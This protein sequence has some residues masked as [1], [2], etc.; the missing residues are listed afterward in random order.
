MVLPKKRKNPSRI[1]MRLSTSTPAVRLLELA[2]L[3]SGTKLST[4]EF[5]SLLVAKGA[6]EEMHRMFPSKKKKGN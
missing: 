4:S 1:K 3:R 6:R 5:A 2:R